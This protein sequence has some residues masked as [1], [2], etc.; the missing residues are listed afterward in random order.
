MRPLSWYPWWPH[1]G[2]FSPGTLADHTR[3]RNL[4]KQPSFCSDGHQY[5]H[6]PMGAQVT[7]NLTQ[8][9]IFAG[10]WTV[11]AF[12]MAAV[13][14]SPGGG[15]AEY[16]WW[17]PVKWLSTRVMSH[18]DNG[19]SSLAP[20]SWSLYWDIRRHLWCVAG[21]LIT[22]PQSEA[23]WLRLLT[24]HKVETPLMDCGSDK[25]FDITSHKLGLLCLHFAWDWE[26]KLC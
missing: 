20:R 21:P 22:R 1:G 24:E 13:A 12:K 9:I 8:P 23:A 19:T 25:C 15:G 3:W 18:N 17:G 4:C 26:S 7:L 5:K 6:N 16:S 10:T 2:G 11:K 14:V